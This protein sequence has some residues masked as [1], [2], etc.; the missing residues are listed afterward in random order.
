MVSG[1]L[2]ARVASKG[3]L[4]FRRRRGSARQSGRRDPKWQELRS[5]EKHSRPLRLTGDNGNS[6]QRRSVGGLF[7]LSG[8]G[9]P[10][11]AVKGEK[12]APKGRSE[13]LTKESD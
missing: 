5:S 8:K 1:F 11:E 6:L 2:H 10:M 7:R 4:V 3:R 9:K 12:P 13:R